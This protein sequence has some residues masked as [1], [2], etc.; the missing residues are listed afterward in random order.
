MKTLQRIILRLFIEPFLSG[1]RRNQTVFVAWLNEQIA[2]FNTE[3][4]K[5]GTYAEQVRPAA[6]SFEP[7]SGLEAKCR[8]IAEADKRLSPEASFMAFYHGAMSRDRAAMRFSAEREIREILTTHGERLRS[9][10][11]PYRGGHRTIA[12]KDEMHRA[13]AAEWLFFHKWEPEL[14]TA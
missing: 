7:D 5:A 1:K 6:P 4:R 12:V 13:V 2:A 3:Q 11:E 9:Y 14:A 10:L 8:L